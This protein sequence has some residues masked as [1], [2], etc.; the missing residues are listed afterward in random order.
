[1][2]P[3]AMEPPVSPAAPTNR[4]WVFAM[5]SRRYQADRYQGKSWTVAEVVL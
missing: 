2:R 1:M 3:L 4:T 5:L